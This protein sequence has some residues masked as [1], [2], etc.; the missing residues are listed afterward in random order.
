VRFGD[1]DVTD[2]AVNADGTE[3]TVVAPPGLGAVDVTVVGTAGCGNATVDDG[4]SYDPVAPVATSLTPDR[5]PET[6]GTSVTITG[7][8]FLGS[9]G[10]TFDG[11]PG[12]GLVVVNDTTITV[13]TPAHAPAT[14][15]VVVNDPSAAGAGR[16]LSYTFQPVTR[17]DGVTPDEGPDSGG[18]TVTITGQCFAGAT[19]VYFGDRQAARY[20]VNADGTVITAV[21]PI[22]NPGT[23]D[24]RVV[25]TGTCGTATAEDAFEFGSTAPASAGGAHV[26]GSSGSATRSGGTL[27]Y[28]GTDASGI[29]ATALAAV[30]LLAAGLALAV[31][32]RR[33]N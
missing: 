16:P 20:T 14:V 27:A 15:G 31:R 3:I 1:T 21:T 25:G 4:F 7:S 28:T 26:V 12:T 9:T 11:I 30:A 29:T 17:I 2:F 18:T 8:G 33:T 6:G 24:I 32:R 19:A 13:T 5:G 23:V 10:V 22:S